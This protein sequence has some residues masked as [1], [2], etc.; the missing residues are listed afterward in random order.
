L[1]GA[2]R[3]VRTLELLGPDATA[4]ELLERVSEQTDARPDD[5][6]ACLLSVH[7]G[8][9]EPVTLVQ[10]LELTRREA[11]ERAERFLLACGMGLAQAARVAR[12]AGVE[13]EQAGSVLLE[14]R[15]SGQ[16]TPS[17]VLRR[18]D[19]PDVHASDNR[20]LATVGAA[21]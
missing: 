4:Q 21:G 11:R 13:A 14:V 7:G 15:L 9:G 12:Q 8:S 18:D 10:E 20:L 17:A 16:D 6:A 5:M 1:Y 19:V 2:E 3:L